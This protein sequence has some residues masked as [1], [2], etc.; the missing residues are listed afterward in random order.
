MV[1]NNKL[2]GHEFLKTT[3]SFLELSYT[4]YGVE[5]DFD[6]I[7]GY[8][9]ARITIGL[10]LFTGNA[11]DNTRQKIGEIRLMKFD[12]SCQLEMD[13][14]DYKNEFYKEEG[15][16]QRLYERFYD[17]D[18]E[19]WFLINRYD[20][21]WVQSIWCIHDISILPELRGHGLMKL[22][23]ENIK[24][25]LMPQTGKNLIFGFAFPVQFWK[26]NPKD[27]FNYVHNQNLEE[28]KQK[29]EKAY[30][31]CGFRFLKYLSGGSQIIGK[32]AALDLKRDGHLFFQYY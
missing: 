25:V 31:A 24:K 17:E 18:Q 26:D 7:H 9:Y 20:G 21:E 8:N 27:A 19:D 11:H 28:S 6:V 4:T 12:N 32:Q 13:N 14:E 30:E 10:Y 1:I 16:F 2:Q 22:D 3:N 29:L 15:Y 23:R 5:G